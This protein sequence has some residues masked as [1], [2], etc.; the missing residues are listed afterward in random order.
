M[1]RLVADSMD[2][3]TGTSKLNELIKE[4]QKMTVAS[5]PHAGG[6]L[7]RTILDLAVQRLFDIN[8]KIAETRSTNGRT[9]GLTRRIK[10]LCNRHSDWFSDRATLE[11]FRRFT[12]GDSESFIHIETLNDYAHGDYGR[13][14]KDDL[15]NFWAHIGPLLDLILEEEN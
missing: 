7:L 11:K 15:R 2:Y 13:P 5:Y 8:G 3:N 9:L 6:L 4:G 14:T 10:K 1:E 12:A